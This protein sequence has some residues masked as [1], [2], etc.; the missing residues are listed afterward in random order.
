[1]S[2]VFVVYKGKYSPYSFLEFPKKQICSHRQWWENE[3]QILLLSIC[4][5]IKWLW[6]LVLCVNLTRLTDVQITGKM[7]FLGVSVRVF[8]EE[9][10]IWISRLINNYP[11][12]YGWASSNLARGWIDQKGEGWANLLSL[13]GFPGGSEVK[14]SAWNAG[15]SGSIPGSERSPGEGNC[16]PLQY[17]CLEN[18]M[19]GGAW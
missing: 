2:R 6:Y 18:P 12:L 4:W 19:E 16:N 13:L 3:A 17:S 8:L 15:D 9:L 10:S 7:L 5:S 1:M 14:A 11:Y